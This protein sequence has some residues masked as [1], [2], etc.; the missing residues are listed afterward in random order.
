MAIQRAFLEVFNFVN[1]VIAMEMSIQMRLA[2]VIAPRASVLSVFTI[3]LDR[4]VNN[5]CRAILVNH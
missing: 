3:Q 1:H 4:I 2:I 5:V